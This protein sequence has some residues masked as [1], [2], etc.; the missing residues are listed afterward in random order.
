MGYTFTPNRD[1]GVV[2]RHVCPDTKRRDPY[3]HSCRTWKEGVRKANKKQRIH[4]IY[5]EKVS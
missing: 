3:G 1:A 4:V 2:R 5:E